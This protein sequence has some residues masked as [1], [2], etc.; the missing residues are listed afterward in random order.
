[1]TDVSELVK[2]SAFKVFTGAVESGG[3]VKLIN[4]KGQAANYSRK[5]IDALGEFAARYG[6][7]GLAWLKV[8]EGGVKGPIA[9]FFEGEATDSLIN[10]AAAEA[11]DLLLF[12]ADSKT[13]V[14]DALGALRMKLGKDLDLI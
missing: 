2:D 6:A 14:A 12:V 1:L 3:Q 10:A 8:E 9:K 7:K 5:D 11:G 4:A 13:V